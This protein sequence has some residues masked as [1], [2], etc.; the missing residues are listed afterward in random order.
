[1]THCDIMKG[2]LTPPE[3]ARQIGISERTIRRWME[4]RL[5]PGKRTPGGRWMIPEYWVIEQGERPVEPVKLTSGDADP[6]SDATGSDFW[7]A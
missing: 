4:R 5:V 6:V 1:M 3:A 7:G 2:Y